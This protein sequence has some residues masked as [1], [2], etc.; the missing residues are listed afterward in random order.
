MADALTTILRPSREAPDAALRA[1]PHAQAFARLILCL[2]ALQRAEARFFATSLA[3]ASHADRLAAC[4]GLRDDMAARVS[5][6]ACLPTDPATAAAPLVSAARLM[7]AWLEARAA[8]DDAAGAAFLAREA[9]ALKHRGE[10]AAAW[11]VGYLVA[12]ALTLFAGVLGLPLGNGLT[13]IAEAAPRDGAPSDLPLPLPGHGGPAF[14]QAV[15]PLAGDLARDTAVS[16][17]G[18]RTH[19]LTAAPAALAPCPSPRAAS[20]DRAL[21]LQ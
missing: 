7:A 6:L 17:A 15:H 10:S 3:D 21:A 13:P 1:C 8:H 20:A 18:G 14:P 12:K 2:V 9:Q 16:L 11:Q 4:D 5:R 19:P